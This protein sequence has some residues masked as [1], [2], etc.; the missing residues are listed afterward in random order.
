MQSWAIQSYMVLLYI[1]SNTARCTY[2]Y[3]CAC[4]RGITFSSRTTGTYSAGQLSRRSNCR[5]YLEWW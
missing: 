5:L 1:G 4:D 3:A 2:A